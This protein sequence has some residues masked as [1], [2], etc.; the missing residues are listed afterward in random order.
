MTN[1]QILY[2]PKQNAQSII[3]YFKK[4][5][6]YFLPEPKVDHQTGRRSLD[7]NPSDFSA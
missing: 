3:N 1:F 4:E 2:R 6:V 7:L 5:I